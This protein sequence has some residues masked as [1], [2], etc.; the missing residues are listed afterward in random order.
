[1]NSSRP[2]E[3]SI[4]CCPILGSVVG[5]LRGLKVTSFR[6]FVRSF[7]SVERTWIADTLFLPCIR[8]S[9]FLVIS[10]HADKYFSDALEMLQIV[11]NVHFSVYLL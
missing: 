4:K 6:A 9:L 1:M 5:C 3:E 10:S 8:I 11:L 7:C 2:P